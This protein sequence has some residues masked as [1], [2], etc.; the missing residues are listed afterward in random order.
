MSRCWADRTQLGTGCTLSCQFL[1]DTTQRHKAATQTQQERYTSVRGSLGAEYGCA[2]SLTSVRLC[3]ASVAVGLTRLL[4]AWPV[5]AGPPRRPPPSVSWQ[6]KLGAHQVPEDRACLSCTGTPCRVF[7]GRN[8]WAGF[9]GPSLHLHGTASY[10]NAP[11]S[12][13]HPI[14]PCTLACQ[15]W[16][17]QSQQHRQYMPSGQPGC[18]LSCRH[19]TRNS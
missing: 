16:R 13:T 2:A 5:S 12:T 11:L 19:H 8:S 17:S 3:H 4:C 9:K 1:A 18:L 10:A 14:L 7:L 15:P 6:K